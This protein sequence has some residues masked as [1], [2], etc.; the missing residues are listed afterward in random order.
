[1]SSAL[2]TEGPRL[3]D[4]HSKMVAFPGRPNNPAGRTAAT[5]EARTLPRPAGLVVLVEQ[6]LALLL[7]GLDALVHVLADLLAVDVDLDALV[8]RGGRRLGRDVVPV[9]VVADAQ[10]GHQGEA[11]KCQ[12]VSHRFLVYY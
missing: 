2:N 11:E 7:D 10:E 8:A 5:A 4:R 12:Q 9:E 3:I 6:V 1:M